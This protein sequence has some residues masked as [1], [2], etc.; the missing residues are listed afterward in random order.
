MRTYTEHCQHHWAK[1][2]KGASDTQNKSPGTQGYLG[3]GLLG[4][5]AGWRWGRGGAAPIVETENGLLMP[6]FRA[7][8]LFYDNV[9]SGSQSLGDFGVIRVLRVWPLRF[10]GGET[11]GTTET[12]SPSER[13]QDV[14]PLF[15]LPGVGGQRRF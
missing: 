6:S 1:G 2:I 3:P 11:A 13:S 4:I 8:S 10:H 15:L 12:R 7:P 14:G 9:P 5:G